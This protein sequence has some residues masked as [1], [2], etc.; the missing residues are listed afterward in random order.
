VS[1]LLILASGC[2]VDVR[3]GLGP[4]VP[5]P[6]IEGTVSRGASPAINVDVELHNVATETKV[7]DTRTNRQ[8]FFAFFGVNPGLWEVRAESDLPGDFASVSRQFYRA[9]GDGTLSVRG[10]DVFAHGAGLLAPTAGASVI[11]PTPFEPLEFHWSAPNISG[12]IAHVQLYDQ[13][14]QS[15]WKSPRVVVDSVQ[16]YGFGSEGSY[17]DVPV[18]P[19]NYEWR[20]KFEFPDTTEARTERRQLR[21]E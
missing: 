1:G 15:V 12:A 17:Q 10:L 3:D 11:A 18:G 16:W 9:D 5:E 8:G 7:F 14:E 13:A 19:G 6:D 21:L 2:A 4:R 20:V